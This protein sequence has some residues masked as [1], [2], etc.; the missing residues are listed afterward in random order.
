MRGRT[1]KR[2]NLI[3]MLVEIYVNGDWNTSLEDNNEVVIYDK[4]TVYKLDDSLYDSFI[5]KLEDEGYDCYF[6]PELFKHPEW[7]GIIKYEVN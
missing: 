6:C 5:D 7:N 4:G 2:L 1:S 3:I